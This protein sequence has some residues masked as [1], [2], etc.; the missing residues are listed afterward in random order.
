MLIT[1]GVLRVKLETSCHSAV[2][3]SFKFIYDNLVLNV[4]KK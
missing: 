4:L 1:I 3:N 2:C